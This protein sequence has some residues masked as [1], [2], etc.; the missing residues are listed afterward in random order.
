MYKKLF[1]ILI[2][3]GCFAPQI[4]AMQTISIGDE[5]NLYSKTLKENRP[6]RVYIPD[7]YHESEQKYPVIYVL[8]G[9]VSFF[10]TASTSQFLSQY[11]FM[12]EAI[13]VAVH[14]TN[15]FRDMP[16]PDTYGRAGEKNF[17]SFLVDEL[18]P[19]I[20]NT[21]RTHPLRILIGHSQG[22]LF[23]NYAMSTSQ[24]TFH[25]FVSLDA[26]LFG[27]ANGFKQELIRKIQS[28][29]YNGRYV[30]VDRSLGWLDEWADF[31]AAAPT[32]FMHAQF[33]A[34]PGESHESMNFEGT[35]KALK[36]LFSD[37]SPA[38]I[39]TK[40][41]ATLQAEYLNRSEQYR[42]PVPIPRRLL[43]RNIDDLI[44]QIRGEEAQ[45]LL[46]YLIEN[47]GENRSTDQLGERVREVLNAE[48]LDESVDDIINYPSPGAEQMAPYLGTWTGT[49]NSRF[50]TDVVITFS[51]QDGKAVGHM[52]R[53]YPD[54][55][56][57]REQL[58]IV[59]ILEDGT[60]EWG[61]MNRM[62]P[63]GVIL[64]TSSQRSSKRIT[65]TQKMKGVRVKFP[66]GFTPPTVTFTL[67]KQE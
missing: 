58:A 39:A 49:I 37:F 65:G 11:G 43:S 42:Y 1:L 31:E 67:I 8:D 61:Y 9:E 50:P 14:N 56:T 4:Q 19:D 22:G 60:F 20:D 34:Q 44:F 16:I 41:L 45:E 57:E 59:R 33:K 53:T 29:G 21:Y 36:Y 62:R 32:H 66:D 24:D 6:F 23:V 48:P 35:Y 55:K 63:R 10:H 64:N 40:N 3:I 26:P 38:D 54:G 12:P 27:D 47:Y 13:V 30:T 52:A 51:M 18:V 15:R 28:R 2:I 5:S 46:G 7:S 25:W 17:L